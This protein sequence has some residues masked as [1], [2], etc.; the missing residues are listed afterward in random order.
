MEAISTFIK[1]I[2]KERFINK[3]SKCS[4]TNNS[5]EYNKVLKYQKIYGIIYLKIAFYAYKQK[6]TAELI[7]LTLLNKIRVILFTVKLNIKF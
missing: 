7:N 4:K 2:Q 3:K 6:G 5:T 1:Y